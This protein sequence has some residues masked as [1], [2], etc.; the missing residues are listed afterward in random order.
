VLDGKSDVKVNENE[1][2]EFLLDIRGLKKKA[3]KDWDVQESKIIVTLLLNQLKNNISKQN[4]NIPAINKSQ[5]LLLNDSEVNESRLP[6]KIINIM[7]RY[8]N[9]RT[10]FSQKRFKEI[11]INSYLTSTKISW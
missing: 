2:D 10:F 1:K 6:S 7:Y 11:Q 3:V 5:I 8:R 4:I 9:I